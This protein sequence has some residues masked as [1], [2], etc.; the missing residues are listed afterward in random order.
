MLNNT[1]DDKPPLPPNE[2]FGYLFCS[3]CALVAGYMFWISH[4]G[5]ASIFAAL[6][7]AFLAA[8]HFA[9][10]VLA[11]L[12]RLWFGFGLLLGK[13]ISPIVLG[14]IFFLLI[15]PVALVTRLFGRD[16]L[17]IRKRATASYWVERD[18]P[19]PA[20]DSFKNQF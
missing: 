3:V 5:W 16:P 6:A 11:P 14:A 17:L 10:S 18:P 2:R 4:P 15:S 9:P 7:V 19:G 12:N 13:I 20:T 8:A 1:T